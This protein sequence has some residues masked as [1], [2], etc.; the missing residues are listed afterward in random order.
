MAKHP[1]AM[2]LAKVVIAAAWADGELAHDEVNSLKNL[3]AE[4]GQTV[5][6]GE[7][8][9]TMQDWAELDIYLFSPVEADERKRLVAD[10]A[11]QMRGAGDRAI[12]IDALNRLMAAD[13]VLTDEER[14][15]ADEIREAI[16]RADAGPLAGL[17]RFLRQNLGLRVGG[18]LGP[19]REQHLEEFLNNRVY[20]AMRVRLGRSPEEGLG[21][22]ADEARKL[23]L[24]G[25]LLAQLAQVEAGVDPRERER[26]VSALAEGWGIT[27][28]RAELVAE[29][30][31]VESDT[32]LDPYTLSYAFA[33]SASNE[34]R[35]RFL[36]ALF[37]VAAADG[38]ISSEESAEISR[39]ANN[40]R[41]EQRHFV[42]AK[43]KAL[44]ETSSDADSDDQ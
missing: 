31:L 9:L 23:A 39:I 2:A 44:G 1:I 19:N 37:A 17:G 10:L 6:S 28:E 34:E 4:L 29:A 33:Q 27:Q 30:A 32:G 8:A 18:G 20:Y 7:M 16:G 14:T 3:L 21:I 43:R 36:D 12:A 24:A 13:R 38:T 41:L 40:I 42:D 15:V 11:G 22:P 35:I 25:G 5:G 26:I